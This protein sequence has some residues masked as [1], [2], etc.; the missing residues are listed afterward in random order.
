M[1]TSSHRAFFFALLFWQALAFTVAASAAEL[2]QPRAATDQ[3][4]AEVT[5]VLSS[6]FGIAA[7]EP[8]EIRAAG[9][10]R[11]AGNDHYL[12]IERTDLK[13][14]ILE[15]AS[16]GHTYK[17]IDEKANSKEVLLRRLSEVLRK[18]APTSEAPLFSEFQ[19]EF[20]GAAPMKAKMAPFDPR[21]SSLHVA[22]TAAYSRMIDKVP[23]FGSELIAGLDSDGSIG[24]LRVHWPAIDPRLVAEAQ[25]LQKMVAAKK[26]TM[27]K[28]LQTRDTEVLEVSAGVGHSAFADPEFRSAAVVRVLARRTARGT[29]YPISSTGYHYYDGGGKEIYFSAFP[30]LPDSDPKSKLADGQRAAKS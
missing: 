15:R 2:P 18:V 10:F 17:A 21:K 22:R 27:P 20:A 5:R 29:Q 16:Y 6:R 14:V 8:L 30:V 7:K 24:R 1:K 4:R 23:I 25:K 11:F 19:D 13:S 9:A 3:E 28:E 12:F 26:W